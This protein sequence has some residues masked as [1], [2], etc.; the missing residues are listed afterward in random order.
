MVT[1]TQILDLIS[2]ALIQSEFVD[3]SV[4]RANQKTIKK[5]VGLSFKIDAI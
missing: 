2:E 5:N 3:V 4:V 1:V